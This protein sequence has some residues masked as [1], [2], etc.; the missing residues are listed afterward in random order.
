MN[1]DHSEVFPKYGCRRCG[2]VE[3]RG[4]FDTYQVYGAEGD[5]LVHLR[6]EFTDP[7]V[8][9]LYCNECGERIPIDDLTEVVV[10]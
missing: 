4:D 3:V 8:L 2:S 1:S 5:K 10:E 9:A 6:S 7:A